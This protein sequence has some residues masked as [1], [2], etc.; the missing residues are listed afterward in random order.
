MSAMLASIREK[1]MAGS[2]GGVQSEVSVV[3]AVE[4]FELL[5]VSSPSFGR[6]FN[7]EASIKALAGNMLVARFTADQTVVQRGESGSWFGI[8][9]TGDLVVELP[10]GDTVSVP[11]GT[12]IGEMT[13]WQPGAVRSATIRGKAPGG[14]IATMLVDELSSFCDANPRVGA[15]LMTLMGR[16][17]IGKQVDNMRRTLRQ[18]D[19]VGHELQ[20]TPYASAASDP[21]AIDASEAFMALLLGRQF[22]PEEAEQLVSECSFGP[23]S[24]DQVLAK[25][26]SSWPSLVAFVL[27]GSLLMEPWSLELGPGSIIGA[28]GFFGETLFGEASSIVATSSGTIATI[29]FAALN[30]LFWLESRA[31]T[32]GA[33]TGGVVFAEDTSLAAPAPAPKSGAGGLLIDKLVRVLGSYAMHMCEQAKAMAERPSTAA[34]P[35]PADSSRPPIRRVTSAFNDS[36]AAAVGAGVAGAPMAS[37][38]QESF[39]AAKLSE[40]QRSATARGSAAPLAMVAAMAPGEAST[41]NDG[42]DPVLGVQ[43]YKVLHAGALGKLGKANA[44]LA[45]YERV[46]GELKSQLKSAK[47]VVSDIRDTV[48]FC[49]QAIGK[50]VSAGEKA[51]AQMKAHG[52]AEVGAWPVLKE[53]DQ[54]VANGRRLTDT[55]S[56]VEEM[57]R[58]RGPED[59]KQADV[60]SGGVKGE[61]DDGLTF[62]ERLGRV[63]GSTPGGGPGAS[64]QGSTVRGTPRDGWGGEIRRGYRDGSGPKTK[65]TAAA[66]PA[67]TPPESL[68]E[69]QRRIKEHERLVVKVAKEREAASKLLEAASRE[70]EIVMNESRKIE[71][72][73]QILE[74]HNAQLIAEQ[75]AFERRKIE[76][77]NVAAAYCQTDDRSVAAATQTDMA[78]LQPLVAEGALALA[79]ERALE[80]E[81]LWQTHG[82]AWVGGVADILHRECQALMKLFHEKTMELPPS[83]DRD[84]HPPQVPAKLEQTWR[85]AL[86]EEVRRQM[87]PLRDRIE[88][89]S[90][91]A[92]TRDGTAQ[93]ASAAPPGPARDDGGAPPQRQSTPSEFGPAAPSAAE[94]RTGQDPVAM[95]GISRGGSSHESRARSPPQ[96]SHFFPE[97]PAAYAVRRTSDETSTPLPS[98]LLNVHEAPKLHAPSPRA[99]RSLGMTQGHGGGHGSARSVGASPR[100]PGGTTIGMLAGSVAEELLPLEASGIAGGLHLPIMSGRTSS[101]ALVYQKVDKE[102]AREVAAMRQILRRQQELLPSLQRHA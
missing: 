40:Q 64:S 41:G 10:G 42:K 50:L 89:V 1:K 27:T 78:L 8:L 74:E 99:R 13:L 97:P 51:S 79:A 14:L 23:F 101:R 45:E 15:K 83:P 6:V 59:T 69:M 25:P 54:L 96:R 80:T 32:P 75:E 91:G 63:G 65:G 35:D 90:S 7:D 37:G 46:N 16:S 92:A 19:R 20:L 82:A 93:G 100:H 34:S 66:K 55:V 71:E 4:H 73:N 39:Y 52:G 22:S 57:K 26:G 21:V 102:I 94:R 2:S 38:K 85:H 18:R 36:G 24:E 81:S 68:G 86:V 17:A 62:E 30:R 76:P 70:R 3:E 53:L 58:L 29:S 9:L 56:A 31:M 95:G 77:I 60:G 47:R 43:H 72:A 12:L 61:D 98:W 28:L 33:H 48:D 84:S 49:T 11:P 88:A 67:I 44:E 5:Q 87:Q